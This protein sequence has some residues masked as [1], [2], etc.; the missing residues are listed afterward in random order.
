MNDQ[1]RRTGKR[2]QRSGLIEVSDDQT[3]ARCGKRRIRRTSERGDLVTPEPVRERASG[4]V[5][6]ADDE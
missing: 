3:N 1:L 5:A 4:H 6:A 2:R